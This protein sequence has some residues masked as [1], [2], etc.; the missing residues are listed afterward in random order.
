MA[1]AHASAPWPATWCRH[2]RSAAA[3][4]I[5]GSNDVRLIL[6]LGDHTQVDTL[7]VYWPS[8]VIQT[9]VGVEADQHIVIREANEERE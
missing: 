9:L 2:E 3:T 7:Q 5:W 8:G 4:A 6:G 1:W